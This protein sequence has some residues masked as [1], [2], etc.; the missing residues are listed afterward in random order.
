MSLKKSAILALLVSLTLAVSGCDLLNQLIG[1][2]N[3]PVMNGTVTLDTRAPAGHLVIAVISHDGSLF[4]GS[5]DNS[6]FFDHE[7]ISIAPGGS[8]QYYFT[9]ASGSYSVGAFYD[10]NDD[11]SFEKGEPVG[12]LGGLPGKAKAIVEGE[13]QS[14]AIDVLFIGYSVLYD[15]NGNTSGA[16]PV[17]GSYWD[18]G[19][20]AIVLGYSGNLA[21]TGFAF[22]GWNTQAGGNGVTYLAGSTYHMGVADV[23]LHALWTPAIVQNPISTD[24]NVPTSLAIDTLVN[25]SI[26]NTTT[27]YLYF[28]TTAFVDGYGV[29]VTPTAALSLVTGYFSSGWVLN[30]VG[31][32]DPNPPS[33]GLRQG[34]KAGSANY[35]AQIGNASGGSA[36]FDVIVREGVLGANYLATPVPVSLGTP[37][38]IAATA[39]SGS[40]CNDFSFVA[41]GATATLQL[42]SLTAGV[43]VEVLSLDRS[44][45]IYGPT[46]DGTETQV[47]KTVSVT[48]LTNGVTYVLRISSHVS[49][50]NGASVGQLTITSP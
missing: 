6:L 40:G 26:A 39:L 41:G 27:G 1:R 4:S 2:S 46:T 24:I 42:D 11:F 43:D 9:M 14:G 15:G 35:G 34:F 25:Y 20:D 22:A 8:G 29:Y 38:W 30:G 28:P 49:G 32:V 36:T 37:T 18:T 17:D 33:N 50:T 3:P 21:K 48:G 44:T 7:A 5:T 16:V 45:S 19:Q 47:T 10:L 13:T 23:T 31:S 12:A